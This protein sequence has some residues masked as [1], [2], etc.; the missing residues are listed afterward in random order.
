MDFSEYRLASDGLVICEP[1]LTFAFFS[2]VQLSSDEPPD[3]LAPYRI[4]LEA[5]GIQ[6]SYCR[7]SGAQMHAK[8]LRTM[9]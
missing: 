8:K 7:T 1:C 5:F 6:V 4:F 2:D 9:T 3:L